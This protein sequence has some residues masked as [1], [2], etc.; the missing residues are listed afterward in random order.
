[1]KVRTRICL[2]TH[3][4]FLAPPFHQDPNP[5]HHHAT[6]DIIIIVVVVAVTIGRG[7]GLYSRR[8]RSGLSRGRSTTIGRAAVCGENGHLAPLAWIGRDK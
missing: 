6:H 7:T 4:N 5:S 1:M 2:P 8:N 3:K